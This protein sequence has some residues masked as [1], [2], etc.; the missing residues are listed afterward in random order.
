MSFGTITSFANWSPVKGA[1]NYC[2]K[3]GGK[4]LVTL[5]R[6]L[7]AIV[8]TWIS[9]FYVLNTYQ[10]KKIPEE[11]KT[12]FAINTTICSII[13]IIGGYAMEPGVERFVKAL[14]ERMEKVLPNLE[15]K[16][17]GLI[18]EGLAASV[19]LFL[20]TFTFRFLGPVIATPLAD[21]INKFLIKHGYIKDPE[22]KKPPKNK[23]NITLGSTP[24]NLSLNTNFDN[25]INKV[26]LQSQ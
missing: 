11:R 13:G 9:A 26:K 17:L 20:F 23:L 25:F 3:D 14:A 7:P 15:K 24:A 18:K 22:A 1:V 5:K 12:P 10:S 19:P 8:A 2:A 21:K 6:H 16:E 4:N